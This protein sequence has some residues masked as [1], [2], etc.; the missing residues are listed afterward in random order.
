MSDGYQSLDF[1]QFRSTMEL[2]RKVAAAV[3]K[4]M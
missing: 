2:C 1:E 4:E 3:G